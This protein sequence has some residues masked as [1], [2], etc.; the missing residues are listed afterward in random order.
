MSKPLPK[1]KKGDLVMNEEK[2]Y[3]T[4]ERVNEIAAKGKEILD[5]CVIIPHA[6]KQEDGSVKHS[7]EHHIPLKEGNDDWNNVL[8]WDLPEDKTQFVVKHIDN[9]RAYAK[10]YVAGEVGKDVDVLPPW[11]LFP[12]YTAD[13]SLWYERTCGKYVK[14]WLDFL[15]GLS[16]SSFVSYQKKFPVPMFMSGTD[17]LG[18]NSL[19]KLVCGC[20]EEGVKEEHEDSAC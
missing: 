1:F 11:L 13:T 20:D 14:K 9:A 10:A 8:D 5:L 7:V 18:M 4:S 15:R 6:D 16:S 12:H 17:Y 19:N 3:W 2:V